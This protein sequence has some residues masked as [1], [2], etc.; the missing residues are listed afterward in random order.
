MAEIISSSVKSVPKSALTRAG[1]SGTNA[2]S[3]RRTARAL[4]LHSEASQRYEKGV[5]VAAID[6]VSRRTMQLLAEL[7]GESQS[8]RQ[9]WPD[10]Q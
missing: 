8:A 5:N 3:I 4:G 9:P 6:D 2:V 7:C 1:R 10:V